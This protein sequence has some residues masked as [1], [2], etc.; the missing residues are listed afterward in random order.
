MG[1][2]CRRRLILLALILMLT[3]FVAHRPTAGEV[4]AKPFPLASTLARLDGW[5]LIGQTPLEANVIEGLQLD[6]YAFLSYARGGDLVSLYVGYYF[7][8][9][10]VGA[11]HHPLVCFSGQGWELSDVGHAKFRLRDGRQLPVAV[12]TASRDV[13]RQ[14]IVYWFQAEEEAASGP[15]GQKLRLIRQRLL[16]GGEQSAFVRLS[17]PAGER[18]EEECRRA[19]EEFVRAFYPTFLTYI[20]GRPA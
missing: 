10:K 12:M 17:L 15:F 18:S 6:D 16:H 13:D 19:M 14:Y 11:P 5:H 9:D 20:Q 7:S 4:P 3:A 1:P 2:L 8:A